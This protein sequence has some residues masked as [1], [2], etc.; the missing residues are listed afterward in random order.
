MHHV[1]QTSLLVS[2]LPKT[3]ITAATSATFKF[4]LGGSNMSPPS[5][6]PITGATFATFAS[7][8]PC[9]PGRTH[10]TLLPH[11]CRHAQAPGPLQAQENQS[12]VTWIPETQLPACIHILGSPQ[13]FA[14]APR[15]SL[16]CPRQPV[17]LHQTLQPP[18]SLHHTQITAAQLSQAQEHLLGLQTL[19]GLQHRQARSQ[20]QSLRRSCLP[21]CG[22]TT[23]C[24]GH[25]PL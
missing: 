17:P 25:M 12:Q 7:G 20:T 8:I 19:P 9:P 11:P 13:E 14:S 4:V 22:C 18:H 5:R 1:Y 16:F 21:C 23:P 3:P 10:Y 15:Q 24:T 6:T 2:P